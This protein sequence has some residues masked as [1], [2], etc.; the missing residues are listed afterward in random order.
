MKEDDISMKEAKDARKYVQSVLDKL[1]SDEWFAGN[2][3]KQFV[4]LVKD[5]CKHQ[6]EQIMLETSDDE[7]NDHYKNLVMFAKQ[8]GYDVPSTY[9][10]MKKHAD[11]DDIKL[12]ES[13]KKDQD[14]LFYLDEGVKSEERAINIYEKFLYDD[15]LACAP[16]LQVIVKSN[17]YDEQQHLEDFSFAVESIQ[18][19]NRYNGNEED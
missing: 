19:F 17:Y 9:S 11:K 4:V 8:N 12:F 1:I 3:Y 18:A 16:Q 7:L 13:C 15:K 2:I 14:A 10:E 5:C 6:I